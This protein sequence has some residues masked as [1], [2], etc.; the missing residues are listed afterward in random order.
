MLPVFNEEWE[1]HFP[2][3]R[4][5]LLMDRLGSHL[6]DT[7]LQLA[8]D[9]N[10]HPFFFLSNATHFLQP[11]DGEAFATFKRMLGLML[12]D[13]LVTSGTFIAAIGSRMYEIYHMN[14]HSRF[15]SRYRYLPP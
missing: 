12:G 11:A 5:M 8:L 15:V 13:A 4:P 7:N 2:G 10:I 1:K 3:L 14:R 9:L 6:T